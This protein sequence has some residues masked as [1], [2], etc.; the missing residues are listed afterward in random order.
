MDGPPGMKNFT[1]CLIN[2]AD[3]AKIVKQGRC[4]SKCTGLVRFIVTTVLCVFFG[5]MT[6]VTTLNLIREYFCIYFRYSSPELSNFTS[7]LHSSFLRLL[8][9]TGPIIYGAL[10]ESSCILKRPTPKHGSV[11]NCINYEQ[12]SLT[13]NFLF[14]VIKFWEFL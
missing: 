4:D 3:P 2:A 10:F 8:L 12:T 7:G 13:Y 1:H 9:I 11:S 6:E 14:K 5:A